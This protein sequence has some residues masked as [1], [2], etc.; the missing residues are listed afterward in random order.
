MGSLYW[1]V[2]FGV[3]TWRIWYWR[4]QVMFNNKSWNGDLIVRDIKA[5]AEKIC[6]TLSSI[7]YRRN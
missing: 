2:M 4:N 5:R 6:S 3:A 7:V 1:H